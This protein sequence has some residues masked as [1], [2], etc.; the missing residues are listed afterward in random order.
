MIIHATTVFQAK[1]T[2]DKAVRDFG[3]A[4]LP[5][6]YESAVEIQRDKRLIQVAIE[7]CRK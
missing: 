4:K 7:E 5:K 2:Y 3:T 1:K 6:T